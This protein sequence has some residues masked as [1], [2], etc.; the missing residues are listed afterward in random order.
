M[1]RTLPTWNLL[2]DY[3]PHGARLSSASDPSPEAPCVSNVPIE[4]VGQI[5]HLPMA[6][7]VRWVVDV[8]PQ[9]Y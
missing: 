2:A 6:R 3:K 9:D 4:E 1:A 7:K 5:Q 8:D